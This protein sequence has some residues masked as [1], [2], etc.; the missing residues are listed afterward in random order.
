MTIQP[1]DHKR[2]IIA[3]VARILAPAAATPPMNFTLRA[4]RCPEELKAIRRSISRTLKV[5][6]RPLTAPAWGKLLGETGFEET[7]SGTASMSLLEP[8][9]IVEDEGV[10][11]AVRFWHNMRRTP[12]PAAGSTP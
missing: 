9:C 7:W 4:D 10:L 8:S 1:D 3:E 2:R 12:E 5:G 6:A 11:G